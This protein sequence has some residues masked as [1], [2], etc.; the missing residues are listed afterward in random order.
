MAAHTI[1]PG[2]RHRGI[3]F[4]L[5]GQWSDIDDPT[6]AEVTLRKLG[7]GSYVKVWADEAQLPSDWPD[8]LRVKESVWPWEVLWF[9][10]D[11][12]LTTAPSTYEGNDLERLGGRAWEI[13]IVGPYCF[14]SQP[15]A[16]YKPD[17]VPWCYG[18][19]PPAPVDPNPPA[20]VDPTT[21]VTPVTPVTPTT[22]PGTVP[23]TTTGSKA[24]KTSPI[25]PVAV[26]MGVGLIGVLLARHTNLFKT[27]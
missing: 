18:M 24:K 27:R 11:W 23:T 20:P 17:Y 6:F 16:A 7:F 26:G 10:A 4:N 14:S 1:I 5:G 21:P 15:L 2:A 12:H 13:T 25:V 22:P 9:E 3:F 8:V 19:Q